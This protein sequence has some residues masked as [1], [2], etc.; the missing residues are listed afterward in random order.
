MSVNISINIF[1]L[2]R[3]NRALRFLHLGVFHT[4]VV[5]DGCIE[6]FYGFSTTSESGV[7]ST[8]NVGV[9]PPSMRGDLFRTVD[10]GAAARTRESAEAIASAFAASPR[11]AASRYDVFFHNCNTFSF[12]LS[13]ALIG[14]AAIA[15]YPLFVPRAERIGRFVF[16]TSFA[17]L[18]A[19]F[20]GAVPFL[21]CAA[22]ARTAEP[23]EDALLIAP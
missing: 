20:R 6:Y 19:L 14:D 7:F 9:L 21:G 15:R 5:I 1:D 10:I 22:R 23:I 12:E 3:V 2:T 11:W 4:S 13:R 18:T 17:Y 16:A 8:C